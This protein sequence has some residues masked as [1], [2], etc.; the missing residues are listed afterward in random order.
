MSYES[1][2]ITT[3][4]FLYSTGYGKAMYNTDVPT[5]T[6]QSEAYTKVHGCDWRSLR[7]PS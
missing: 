1:P 5:D 2:D 7:F 3:W 4:V 6:R